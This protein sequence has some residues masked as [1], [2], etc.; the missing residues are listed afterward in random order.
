[1]AI[2]TVNVSALN[3]FLNR[4]VQPYLVRKAEEI[5]SEARSLAPSGG[6]GD[7]KN[8]IHVER[9]P[10]GGATVKVD[11]EHAGFVHQGTGPGHI[12]NAHP[13]YFPRV[14]KRGLILWA[15]SKGANPYKVASGISKS[16]TRANPFLDE[17]VQKVLGRF[18]FR[19]INKDLTIK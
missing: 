12:P 6:T 16:G 18:Q 19:W 14:R 2:V 13:S 8:S 7:L 5:A 15:D 4:T 10:N 17:A 3:D 11:S 1:M 9:T